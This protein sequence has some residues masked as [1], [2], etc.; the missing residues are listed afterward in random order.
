MINL[1][2]IKLIFI[3]LVLIPH[4]VLS[5][6]S[7]ST[8]TNLQNQFSANQ[9]NSVDNYQSGLRWAIWW[10]QANNP[11]ND[12]L[13]FQF[14][15]VNFPPLNINFQTFVEIETCV[16][17]SVPYAYVFYIGELSNSQNQSLTVD[18][19]DKGGYIIDNNANRL[20]TNEAYKLLVLFGVQSNTPKWYENKDFSI[21]LDFT[22][23]GVTFTS[24]P[25]LAYTNDV[26]NFQSKMNCPNTLNNQS[27]NNNI[28]NTVVLIAFSIPIFAVIIYY[29][30]KNLL[31]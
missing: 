16:P 4:F 7:V 14:K 29:A 18:S 22:I 9:S 13:S 24:S 31:K 6:S 11:P 30:K 12:K 8:T 3:L 28:L 19:L 1:K 15:I 21:Q 27:P 10:G 26:N 17:Q 5:S 25:S 20:Q 2:D 23:S